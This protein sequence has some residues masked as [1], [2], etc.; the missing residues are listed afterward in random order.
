MNQAWKGIL[1]WRSRDPSQPLGNDSASSHPLRGLANAQSPRGET[2]PD[3][4]TKAR[5]IHADSLATS[6]ALSELYVPNLITPL[7]VIRILNAV[8]VRFMLLGAHGIGGWT[9]EPRATKDVD[10]LVATR[11]HKKAVHALHSAFAHLQ[12]ED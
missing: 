2:R 6:S 1:T 11:G 9:H 8:K 5:D 3:M 10:V 12:V 7:Q 4:P